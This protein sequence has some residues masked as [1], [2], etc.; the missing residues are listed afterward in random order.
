MTP[1]LDPRSARQP[2]QAFRFADLFIEDLGWNHPERAKPM[3]IEHGGFTY[4][5][6]EIS[7]LSGFRVFEVVTA[8]PE[9][10]FPDAK[11]QQN[12]WKRIAPHAVENLLIFLDATRTRSVWLWMKRDGAKTCLNGGLFLLHGIEARIEG[13][14][15]FSKAYATIKVPDSW[16]EDIF[17]LFDRYS[18]SLSDT[19]GGD[20]REINPDVLGHIFE[21]YINQK[22]FGAYY[23]R[24]EIT[25]YLCEQTITASRS[26][27]STRLMPRRKSPTKPVRTPIPRHA[28]T[29]PS[30]ISCS[31]PPA[32]SARKCCRTSCPA[33]LC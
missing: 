30:R 23:T 13:E 22:E 27:A 31:M 6:H 1:K 10:S 5:A 16:F 15:L 3:V 11:T 19:P 17:T 2:L 29:N 21:K 4:H 24:P 28:A 25:D 8:N 32:R 18:W 12:V 7:Q 20:D 9:V 33:S 26:T 14:A